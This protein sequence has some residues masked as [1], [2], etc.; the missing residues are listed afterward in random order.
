MGPPLA[1]EV[2]GGKKQIKVQVSHHQM[3]KSA[4]GELL[5]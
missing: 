5:R 1:A 3:V 2:G 4:A